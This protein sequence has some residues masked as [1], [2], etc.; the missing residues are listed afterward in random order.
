MRISNTLYFLWL[1]NPIFSPFPLPLSVMILFQCL[2][3]DSA[4]FFIQ[5]SWS[6]NGVLCSSCMGCQT[7]PQASPVLQHQVF[8]WSR[9]PI[10]S[11]LPVRWNFQF[12][13][14]CSNTY[15]LCI[16]SP[17]MFSSP[18]LA[19]GWI[20]SNCWTVWIV[21]PLETTHRNKSLPPGRA[22][23]ESELPCQGYHDGLDIG[24]GLRCSPCVDLLLRK[25]KICKMNIWQWLKK[26]PG[27]EADK[28]HE[29]L[30]LTAVV[31]K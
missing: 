16:K 14:K 10:W 4:N 22:Y 15:Q 1:I 25:R 6:G 24:E 12:T 21:Q 8:F 9:S 13:L 26:V 30:I 20:V 7:I 18:D 11:S 2:Q 17:G 19:P 29:K 3:M 28:V 27:A 31:V 23:L 5:I